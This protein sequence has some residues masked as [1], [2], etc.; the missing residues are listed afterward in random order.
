[1]PRK[2][3]EALGAAIFLSGG[4]PPSPPEDLAPEAAKQLWARVVSAFAADRFDPGNLPLL[5]RYC[6]TVVYVERL[7][8]ALDRLELG[9]PEAGKLHRQ[10]MSGNNSLATLASSLR[11][12][13]QAQVDR[14]SGKIT[15]RYPHGRPWEDEALF[16]GRAAD[17]RDKQ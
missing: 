11:L 9:T 12:S 10:I 2:S 6:R 5:A 16:G 17:W 14:R 15:E 13:V 4:N 3:P 1:M 7:H 8:D